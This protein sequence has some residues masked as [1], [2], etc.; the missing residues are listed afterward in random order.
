MDY[1][2]HV[3]VQKV[4]AYPIVILELVGVTINFIVSFFFFKRRSELGNTL[5]F[6]LSISDAFVCL[7]DAVYNYLSFMMPSF[8]GEYKFLFMMVAAH[9][10][11][12]SLSCTG[13]VTIHL[14]IVRTSVII[15]PM[16]RIKKLRLFISMITLILMYT[17]WEVILGIFYSYPMLS[18]VHNFHLAIDST[19]PHSE[20]HPLHL[21]AF[22]SPLISG[23]PILLAVLVCCTASAAT[24]LSSDRNLGG[25]YDRISKRKAAVTV[26]ILSIEYVVLNGCGLTL[27]SISATYQFKRMYDPTSYLSEMT[28]YKLF[29]QFG[30]F[31]IV[32]S[33]ILNPIVYCCRFKEL[34]ESL[35][36]IANRV[37]SNG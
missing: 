22:F 1:H 11:R 10:S 16:V 30:V 29:Q 26:L 23:T 37:V 27:F 28:K 9:L 34:R 19:L 12:I 14:N 32:M 8:F 7:S 5:L 6:F 15:W 33:S 13:I 18:Y 31:A 36:H 4:I 20:N 17:L 3:D 24:L 21:L 35:V 25:N 2:N